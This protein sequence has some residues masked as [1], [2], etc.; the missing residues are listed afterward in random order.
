MFNLGKSK[1]PELTLTLD[2]AD[3]VYRPGDLIG[4]VV[5][6]LPGKD[7]RV[8]SGTVRLAGTVHFQVRS[9]STSTDSDGHA[10]ESYSYSWERDDLYAVQ[11]Q[12][13]GETTLTRDVPQHYTFQVQLPG[14]ARPSAIGKILRVAWQVEVKFDRPMAGDLRAEAELRVPARAPRGPAAPQPFGASNEPQEADLALVLPG[15]DAVAGQPFTGELRILPRKDF[16]VTDVRLE[17]TRHENVPHDQGHTEDQTVTVKLAGG[18]KFKAGQLV[19]FA[20]QAPLPPDAA[21]S[22]QTE[23]GSLTWA[24]TGV[25]ARRLRRDTTIRQELAVFTE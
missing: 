2:R 11:D 1:T 3:G 21:P 8:R 20:F 10:S 6:L 7:Y 19:T 9:K 16:G 25:L 5:D 12:F 14:D 23:H 4:I 24:L 22:T 18:T 15:A 13:L 17:L